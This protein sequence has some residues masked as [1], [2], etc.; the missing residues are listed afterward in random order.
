[1]PRD[2]KREERALRACAGAL[3]AL[4]PT[5]EMGREGPYPDTIECL[6]SQEAQAAHFAYRLGMAFARA[7]DIRETSGI[8]AATLARDIA[9]DIMGCFRWV[10]KFKDL[11]IPSPSMQNP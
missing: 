1:M 9:D 5:I 6:S 2:P 3:R 11:E 8:M 7:A 10:E 4:L